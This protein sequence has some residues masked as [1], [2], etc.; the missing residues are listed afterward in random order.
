MG[1][2]LPE[3]VSQRLH[4]AAGLELLHLVST[5]AESLGPETVR[6]VLRNPHCD[7]QVIRQLL[8]QR[9]LL[10]SYDVRRD[11]AFH[12]RTPQAR[13]LHLLS[14]LYGRDLLTLSLD[15]RV[16]PVVRR[17]AELR[18]AERLPAMTVGE[19]VSLARRASPGLVKALRTD[20]SPRVVRALL[21][22]PRLTEADV[23]PLASSEATVPSVLA[24]LVA[25][26]RW[27]C[28]YPVRVA[29]CRNPRTPIDQALGLLPL[30]KKGDLRAVSRDLRLETAV[31]R[32]ASLLLGEL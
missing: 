4:E 21:E 31:R 9:R 29:L 19:K 30:L 17:A 24:V 16:P 12:P 26:R 8:A 1:E 32:R 7:Q 6:A 5:Y 20:P 14:G 15:M 22:N 10:D 3:E 13:A 2:E 23:L 18:L 27:G 28:R 25:D 11:L